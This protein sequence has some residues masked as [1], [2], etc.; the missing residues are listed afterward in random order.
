MNK[1]L[2]PIIPLGLFFILA[3]YFLFFLP[4]KGIDFGDETYYLYSAL[5]FVKGWKPD[6]LIPLAPAGMINAFFFLLGIK[7]YLFYRWLFAGF[8]LLSVTLFI[9]GVYSSENRNISG[10]WILTLCILAVY[11]TFVSVLGY[12]NAPVYFL[13]MGF[14]FFYY[15]FSKR[16]LYQFILLFLSACSIAISGFINLA[17]SPAAFLCA[18]ACSFLYRKKIRYFFFSCSFLLVYFLLFFSYVHYA[19]GISSLFTLTEAHSL[20]KT[21]AK[22]MELGTFFIRAGGLALFLAAVKYLLSKKTGKNLIFTLGLILFTGIASYYLLVSAAI[23]LN[24]NLL[25]SPPLA[26]IFQTLDRFLSF[27]QIFSDFIREVF[28]FQSL[29]FVFLFGMFFWKRDPLFNKLGLMLILVLGYALSQMSSSATRIETLFIFYSGPFLI[30]SGLFLR[31]HLEESR[32]YSKIQTC[33]AFMVTAL[34]V[35]HSI[36]LQLYN[37]VDDSPIRIPRKEVKSVERLKGIRDIPYKTDLIERLHQI[38]LENNGKEKSFLSLM[39]WPFWYYLLEREPV[40]KS[41]YIF[42]PYNWPEKEIMD[43]LRNSPRGWIVFWSPTY[44]VNNIDEVAGKVQKFLIENS[45]EILWYGENFDTEIA[46][47]KTHSQVIV[48]IK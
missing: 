45:K 10:T 46:H 18:A 37:G 34:L 29:L 11:S 42:P 15:S 41:S 2:P 26:K 48:Y 7:S 17:L 6:C 4:N 12:A 1:I 5:T 24:F 8:I 35:A 32:P 39:L 44:Q 20:A 25:A 43:Y 30:F 31:N 38:Y 21:T 16:N 33:L 9:K 36:L 47:R 3:L 40:G 28:A 22:L 23:A 14:G 27:G 13:L 19:G